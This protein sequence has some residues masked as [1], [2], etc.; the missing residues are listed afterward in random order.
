MAQIISTDNDE[1][2]RRTAAELLKAAGEGG[3]ASVRTVTGQNGR[4]AFSV[5]DTDTADDEPAKTGKATGKTGKA[6]RARG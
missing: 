3:A 4:V 1:H 6:S 2:A 5:A